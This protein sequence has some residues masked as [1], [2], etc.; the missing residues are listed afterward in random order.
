MDH[1]TCMSLLW[2]IHSKG[3][4]KHIETRNKH[5]FKTYFAAVENENQNSFPYLHFYQ[6][7]GEHDLAVRCFRL[8]QTMF[9]DFLIQT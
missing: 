6:D 9:N 2:V 3:K 1:L 4:K 5:N 8:T 7:P